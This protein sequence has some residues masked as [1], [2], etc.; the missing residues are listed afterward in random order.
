MYLK[1]QED[2]ALVYKNVKDAL[3]DFNYLQ[4]IANM[5]KY[6]LQTEFYY[7]SDEKKLSFK[8]RETYCRGFKPSS[9]F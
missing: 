2:C 5:Y 8:I 4:I 6:R 9:L 7:L 3:V 1:V